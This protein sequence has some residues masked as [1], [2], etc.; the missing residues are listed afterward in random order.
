MATDRFCSI[1]RLKFEELVIDV[2]KNHNFEYIIGCKL[3]S[4]KKVTILTTNNPYILC[5][6]ILSK[7]VNYHLEYDKGVPRFMK[8]AAFSHLSDK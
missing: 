4:N 3:V 1:F 2:D 8:S 6:A 5:G 7:D